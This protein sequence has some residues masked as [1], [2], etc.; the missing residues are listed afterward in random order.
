LNLPDTLEVNRIELFLSTQSHHYI[1]YKFLPG[2]AASFT[3]ALRIQN[4]STGAGSSDGYNTMV[5]AFQASRN[6]VLP[7]GTAYQW[8]T[9]SVLDLNHHFFNTNIDSVLG[10]DVYFNVYTQP[11]RNCC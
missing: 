11:K 2:A 4:P 8:E 9:S 6:D 7:T 3:D 5:S 10:A 1:I